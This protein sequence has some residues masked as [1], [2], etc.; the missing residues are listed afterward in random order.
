MAEDL[1]QAADQYMLEGLKHLCEAAIS[2]SLSVESL[3]AVYELSENFN[4]PQLSRRC[5]LF[6]LEFYADMVQVGGPVH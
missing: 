1:L 3:T 4:A 6:T 5:V 2:T